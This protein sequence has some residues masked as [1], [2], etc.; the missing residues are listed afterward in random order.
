M[1][2]CGMHCPGEETPDPE[3]LRCELAVQPQQLGP[4]SEPHL[5]AQEIELE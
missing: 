2:E 3:E 4:F 5:W 1:W